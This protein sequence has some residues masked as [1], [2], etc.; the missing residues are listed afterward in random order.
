MLR[1]EDAD[2]Y[3]ALPLV[4]AHRQILAA[5]QATHFERVPYQ[6]CTVYRYRALVVTL[7]PIDSER[8][9]GAA[10]SSLGL[11]IYLDLMPKEVPRTE[12]Q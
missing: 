12:V 10:R 4:F 6:Y 2:R 11:L 3:V 1:L 7:S 9:N 5:S 8:R